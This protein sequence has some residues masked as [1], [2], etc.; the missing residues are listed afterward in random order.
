MCKKRKAAIKEGKGDNGDSYQC[1]GCF[2]KT[3]KAGM[4]LRYDIILCSPSEGDASS[5][6]HGYRCRE[7][8]DSRRGWWE[9]EDLDS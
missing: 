9:G 7:T 4:H 5:D 3:S 1:Q 8:T 2:V 6:V